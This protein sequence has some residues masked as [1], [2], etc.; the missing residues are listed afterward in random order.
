M[1]GAKLEA[2]LRYDMPPAFGPSV[3]PDVEAGFDLHG[4]AVEFET[5]PE[6]LAP[7]LPKWFR[8]TPRPVVSIGYRQMI[9]MGWMGGRNYQLLAV[10]ASVV[11]DLDGGTAA[12]TFGLV[13]W[14]SDC[15]PILA[16]R[17]LM[18]APKLF[19]TIPPIEV[20]GADHEFE[21]REYDALLIRARTTGLEE[22]SAAEVAV[23]RELQSKSWVYYWKYIPSVA[24]E[25]D[26]DYPV[27]IKLHTPF[28]RMWK[29]RGSLEL[30][31][32]SAADAPYSAR[33]LQRLAALPRRSELSSNAWHASGCTLLRNQTRRLDR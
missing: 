32:P 5:T 25:P 30:G 23:K 1:A 28:V 16:G 11:C 21:C 20:S 4:S 33:I 24:G 22:L 17:E 9:G 3:A 31:A 8:P 15:A 12:N 14:E 29:G 26:A 2:G 18:G 6:A 7:L 13:I 19:G 10:R 27:A